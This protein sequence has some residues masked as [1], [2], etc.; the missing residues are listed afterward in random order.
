MVLFDFLGGSAKSR[1]SG[2]FSLGF[3]CDFSVFPGV[4]RPGK[5]R[6]PD[7][8]FSWILPVLWG[9][10]AGSGGPTQNFL[11]FPGLLAQKTGENVKKYPKNQQ[12]SSIF[13]QKSSKVGQKSSKSR[14]KSIF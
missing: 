14:Q 7:P 5:K 11:I 2:R 9:F 8:P 3:F 4:V 1:F 6:G 10:R 12:K 13:V